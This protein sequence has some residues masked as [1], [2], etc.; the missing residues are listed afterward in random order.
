MNSINE[1]GLSRPKKKQVGANGKPTL[2]RGVGKEQRDTTPV[3]TSI[4]IPMEVYEQTRRIAFEERT[5]RNEQFKSAWCALTKD[6]MQFPETLI[7][8][9]TDYGMGFAFDVRVPKWIHERAH[10]LKAES[11]VSLSRQFVIA[12]LQQYEVGEGK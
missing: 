3:R 12:W 11:G 2:T 10:E 1:P 8:D 6:G 5:S 4:K 7:E 9:D